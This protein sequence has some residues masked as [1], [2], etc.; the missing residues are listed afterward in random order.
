MWNLSQHLRRT[1]FRVQGLSD[2]RLTVQGGPTAHRARLPPLARGEGQGAGPAVVAVRPQD[3]RAG[4]H[5]RGPALAPHLPAEAPGRGEAPAGHT[6]QCS[7]ALLQLHIGGGEDAQ[8][9][10]HHTHW[11]RESREVGIRVQ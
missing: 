6:H 10:P 1:L 3:L 2:G 4:W 5:P 11:R 9:G 7:A 8:R